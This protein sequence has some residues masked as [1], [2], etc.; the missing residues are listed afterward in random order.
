MKHFF[1]TITGKAIL[2]VTCVLSICVLIASIAGAVFMFEEGFY[3]SSENAIFGRAVGSR[4][5]HQWFG[6]YTYKETAEDQDEDG[7]TV[8][9]TDSNLMLSVTNADGEMIARTSNVTDNSAVD[10]RSFDFEATAETNEYYTLWHCKK[11]DPA[12]DGYRLS[13]VMEYP[14][15]SDDP[16]NDTL[17]IHAAFIAGMPENDIYALTDKVIHIGYSLRYR[18]YV[19]GVIAALL[20]LLCF[21]SLMCVSARKPE[22]EELHPGLL[23]NVPSDVITVIVF[24]LLIVFCGFTMDFFRN[25]TEATLFLIILSPFMIALLIGW[26]MEIASRLKQ[27]SLFKNTLLGKLAAILW[28]GIK[29]LW[30]LIGRFFHMIWNLIGRFFRLIGTLIAAI[31][32]AWKA[33]AVI[34]VDSLF[35]IGCMALV[36]NHDSD[37]A[38][39]FMIFKTLLLIGAGTYLFI[40]MRILQRGAEALALGNLN[41]QVD[42]AGMLADMR[43]HGENL[44]S[45]G[46]VIQT[47]VEE[48]TKSDRMKA[49]LITNVSHDIKTPLTS[50]INYVGLIAKEEC[51]N[52][53][54]S[55]YCEVLTRQS[56]RLKKLIEDLVEASKASTGNL[57]VQLAPCDAGIFLTQ[58]SGEYEEKLKAAN[59]TL[60]VKEPEE[61]LT[62]LA[63]G[64]RMWRIFDNLMNN[65]CKYSMPGTRVYLTLEREN[66]MALFRF[67]NTSKEVLDI[68]E[69]ELMERFVR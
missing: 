25:D 1:R 39:T 5:L 33:L 57:D 50:I 32:A 61:K 18:I 19:I 15:V 28:K 56:G 22:D 3:E 68:S 47:A 36:L 51:N 24:V 38:I 14:T 16:V 45:I 63:D 59:L 2:F 11:I 8:Y 17:I 23:N 13:Y 49:E 41:Y 27:H 9:Y 40:K 4:I 7:V 31:P 48:R 10:A 29:L 66:D 53:K 21:I 64:R 42:T 6:M 43:R 12:N 30:N 34:G 26:C 35:N 52:T 67:K 54:H 46:N 44:N 20:A 37:V 69:D 62:I 60:I 55:E 65:I 58:A